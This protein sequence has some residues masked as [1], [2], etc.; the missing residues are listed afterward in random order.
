[1]PATEH[2]LQGLVCVY[3]TATDFQNCGVK[4][5]C[6]HIYLAVEFIVAA[7]DEAATFS[8]SDLVRLSI[9]LMDS[10]GFLA[11]RPRPVR[12]LVILDSDCC[13]RSDGLG[14]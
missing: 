9:L 8:C 12:P 13:R 10:D 4:F 3:V 6:L 5:H 11:L 2:I 7:M 14:I 1:M